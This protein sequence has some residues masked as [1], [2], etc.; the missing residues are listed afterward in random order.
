MTI[1]NI[2]RYLTAV[3]AEYRDDCAGG[4]PDEYAAKT[5]LWKAAV[6]VWEVASD[7][8]PWIDEL[9][10]IA[11][12]VLKASRIETTI[13]SARRRAVRDGRR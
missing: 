6:I 11:L 12:D 8:A 13:Q 5:A 7:P 10:L 4:F 1:R 9:R 3:I 2:E